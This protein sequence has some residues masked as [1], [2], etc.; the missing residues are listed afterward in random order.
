MGHDGGDAPGEFC[1]TLTITDV[2]TG[3]VDTCTG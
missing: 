1:R 2:D 3:C